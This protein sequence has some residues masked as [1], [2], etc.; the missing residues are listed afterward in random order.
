MYDGVFM[1]FSSFGKWSA[2]WPAISVA[3]FSLTLS[4]PARGEPAHPSTRELPALMMETLAQ[5][6][7]HYFASLE[8]GG[9]AELT[10]VPALQQAAEEVLATYAPPFGAAV[11]VSIPDGRVLAMAG[12]SS[13]D[14]TLGATELALRPWAPAAS[15][16]KVVAASALVAEAGLTAGSRICY[17][18]GVSSVLPDNLVDLPRLDRRCDTLGYAVG[19]S[20]N[21]IIAKLS[22]R[23]LQPKA[24]R[25]VAEAFGFGVTIPFELP[26]EASELSIP[27]EPLEFARASAGFWHS[28]LSAMH[29]ALLA[30]AI[31][32]AGEMPAPRL[33][34]RAMDGKGQRISIDRR[35]AHRVVD[36]AVARQVGHM[37]EL[38]TRMG[39]ARTSF[40][41]RR[42]RPL[43][44]VD[45]AGKT[46]S[47]NYRGQ[48]QDPALPALLPPAGGHL[49]YSWFVGFAPAQQPRIAFAVVLGNA[50]TWR[51]KAAFVA[52]RLVE[53]H[54]AME[55]ELRTRRV[56]AA[57]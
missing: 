20:Q 30:A 47:L 24:L 29:G 41:D 52:R 4:L 54:L 48:P 34:T 53:Q 46:G 3:A 45:V 25:R 10:L 49:G 14:P 55:N 50:A 13:L 36:P 12:R 2:K 11:V 17:H 8:G 31:G 19:K 16:F 26:V 1:V 6:D 57:R 23:H 7:G 51:I 56:V 28:S 40:H 22:A 18:G 15:V 32:N 21:A 44:S 43:L 38:T 35:P 42:G 37:M 5:R 33:V 39:T 9:I 27:E